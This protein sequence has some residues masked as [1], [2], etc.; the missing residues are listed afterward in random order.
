MSCIDEYDYHPHLAFTPAH[1]RNHDT[2][3][4][5]QLRTP[6]LYY[7]GFYLVSFCTV[8]MIVYIFEKNL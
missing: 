6:L 3:Y 4:P 8:N 2:S 7:D 1:I 5:L